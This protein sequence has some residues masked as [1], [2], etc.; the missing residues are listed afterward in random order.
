MVWLSEVGVRRSGVSLSKVNPRCERVCTPR[1]AGTLNKKAIAPK[2]AT[3]WCQVALGSLNAI[4][5]V[6]MPTASHRL[7]PASQAH[8]LIGSQVDTTSFQDNSGAS[9]WAAFRAKR[10]FTRAD[11]LY[12]LSQRDCSQA[13]TAAPM[14]ARCHSARP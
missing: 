4:G 9:I 3:A 10:R 6:V 2:A 11:W 5:R 8:Q 13:R 1:C 14:F 7:K 12:G